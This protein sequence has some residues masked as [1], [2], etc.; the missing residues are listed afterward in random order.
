MRERIA[1]LLLLL[2][3]LVSWGCK[4]KPR[5]PSVTSQYKLGEKYFESSEYGKAAEAYEQYLSESP[6]AGNRDRALFH[7]ALAYSFLD[8]PVRDLQRAIRTFR[9]LVTAFPE[10]PHRREAEVILSLQNSAERLR[11]DVRERDERIKALN[12]ELE[13]L[14]KMDMQRRPPRPP[15]E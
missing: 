7:L 1:I 9:R 5:T 2:L 8:S 14:K 4:A 6:A 15:G 3:S 10:S 13:Q 12:N 11:A